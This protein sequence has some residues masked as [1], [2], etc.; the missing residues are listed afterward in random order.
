MILA[1]AEISI[2]GSD[3]VC[4]SLLAPRAGIS[5]FVLATEYGFSV[6]EV[7]GSYD[8]TLYAFVI[9]QLCTTESY[10]KWFETWLLQTAVL[11]LWNLY[12]FQ[13]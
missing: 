5:N 9:G 10:I 4:R 8:T 12:T 3:W 11:K 1:Y 7:I 13:S 2:F 6:F